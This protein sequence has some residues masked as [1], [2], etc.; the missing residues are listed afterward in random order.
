MILVA[1]KLISND[2][3]LIKI[4]HI[5]KNELW[6]TPC[7]GVYKSNYEKYVLRNLFVKICL[8]IINKFFAH[9]SKL[10]CPEIPFFMRLFFYLRVKMTKFYIRVRKMI[11]L[12]KC[13]I[14]RQFFS[15]DK[16]LF[17]GNKLNVNQNVISSWVFFSMKINI[18]ILKIPL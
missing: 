7:K 3:R 10:V 4:E 2:D 9:T 13:L 14:N 8:V 11:W 6:N 17:L 12:C 1:L 15:H 18:W 5:V 16:Y